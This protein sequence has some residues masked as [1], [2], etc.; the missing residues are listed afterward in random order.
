MAGRKPASACT[1]FVE[2]CEHRPNGCIE[3]T[4]GTTRRGW[5]G[6]GAFWI[7]NGMKSAHRWLYEQQH[8]ELPD[9]IDVC[10]T[11]DNR[12]CVNID[13]LFAGTRKENMEDAARK[14]RTD[15]THKPKGE[16]HGRSVL[17]RSDAKEIRA[18]RELGL[19]LSGISYLFS[20]SIANVHR[21]VHNKLWKE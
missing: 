9:N 20:T 17:K 3:W 10:H 13:H 14:G 19:T 18:L 11:C 12:K 8:G 21:I 2:K 15:R 1:R 6:Y 16:S 4:G 5:R 7:S